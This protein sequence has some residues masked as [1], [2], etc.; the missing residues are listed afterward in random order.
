[1]LEILDR[2]VANEGSI[3]DLDLLEELAED[4]HQHRPLRPGPERL[5]ARAVSTL[6][7]FRNEYLAHVVDHHCPICNGRKAP[8]W[9]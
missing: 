1:M 8:P 5:Q 2:I 7:Y 3:E 9:W 4:H 6:R